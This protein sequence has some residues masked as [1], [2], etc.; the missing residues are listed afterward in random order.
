MSELVKRFKQSDWLEYELETDLIEPPVLKLK[1]TPLNRIYSID[2]YIGIGNQLKKTTTA[3]VL[4]ALIL[5]VVQEWDLTL[6]GKPVP[7]TDENKRKYLFPLLG[8]K[9]K[10]KGMTLLGFELFNYVADLDNFEEKKETPKK[11][12]KPKQES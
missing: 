8:E 2:S 11:T 12:K 10:G 4:A 7:V 6:K 3:Q 1:V 9:V 5:D